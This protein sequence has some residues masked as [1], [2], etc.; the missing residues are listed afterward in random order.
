MRYKLKHDCPRCGGEKVQ[1]CG[2]NEL[3][4]KGVTATFEGVCV[5]CGMYVHTQRRAGVGV[6]PQP[7][8]H[9][10]DP[11][12]LYN[13]LR[14]GVFTGYKIAVPSHMGSIT[15]GK[16][17][18]RLDHRRKTVDGWFPDSWLVDLS[19]DVLLDS[20]TT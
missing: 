11:R 1:L 7:R 14:N 12:A 6:I 5:A 8:Q 19:A 9:A 18:L 13:V 4:F 10:S 3:L 16:Y 15:L 2:V 20:V 17:T